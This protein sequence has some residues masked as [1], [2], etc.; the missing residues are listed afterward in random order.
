[1]NISDGD[2]LSLCFLEMIFLKIHIH[3]VV[4]GSG[5]SICYSA[6]PEFV[7]NLEIDKPPQD[8]AGALFFSLS[9]PEISLHLEDL[10]QDGTVK[11]AGEGFIWARSLFLLCGFVDGRSLLCFQLSGS[12]LQSRWSIGD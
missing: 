2:T 11:A 4:A 9:R 10:F 8:V 12:F 5:S 1:M 6:N 7:R 3:E